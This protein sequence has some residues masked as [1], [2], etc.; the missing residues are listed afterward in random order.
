MPWFYSVQTST[1][2]LSLTPLCSWMGIIG[3]VALALWLAWYL[4]KQFDR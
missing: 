3:L 2:G 4:A 1:A